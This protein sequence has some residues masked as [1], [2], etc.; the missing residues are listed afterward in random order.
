MKLTKPTLKQLIK[1]E[2][3]TILE[4]PPG[5]ESWIKELENMLG[6]LVQLYKLM[7]DEGKEYLNKNLELYVQKWKAEMEDSPEQGAEYPDLSMEGPPEQGTEYP[8]LSEKKA[9]KKA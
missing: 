9:K 8:G 1:E 7:P 2:L 3:S 6:A 5:D 4:D